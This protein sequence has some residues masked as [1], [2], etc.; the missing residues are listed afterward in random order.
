MPVASLRQS[1]TCSSCGVRLLGKGVTSF[2]CPSCGEGKM[3]RCAQCRDQ[4]VTYS[5]AKCGFQGP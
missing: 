1:E 5:C 3:G 4:S 2:A